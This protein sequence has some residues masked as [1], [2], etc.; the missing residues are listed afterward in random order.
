MRA[1]NVLVVEDR[2][3]STSVARLCSLARCLK[4]KPIKQKRDEKSLGYRKRFK[5]SKVYLDEKISN[6][7]MYS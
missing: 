7:R 4:R 5:L 2:D 3:G 1:C 6:I